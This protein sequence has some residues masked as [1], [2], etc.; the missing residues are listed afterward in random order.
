MVLINLQ[1]SGFGQCFIIIVISGI[2][3]FYTIKY[4][5]RCSM[6]EEKLI[7]FMKMNEEIITVTC[8]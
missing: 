3:T 2:M 4:Q 6:F 8:L 5:R 1:N 7:F